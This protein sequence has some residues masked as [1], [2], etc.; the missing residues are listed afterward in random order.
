M[1]AEQPAPRILIVQTGTAGALVPA[2]GD[3]P[4]W[5]RRALGASE[6]QM[7]V[8]RTAPELGGE[9]LDPEVLF[10]TKAKGV[11]VTGSPLSAAAKEGWMEELGE[12]LL[13]AG[14]AG[15]P[16]LGVCFGHQLLGQSAGGEVARNPR[17]REIGTVQVQLTE[18]GRKDPLFSWAGA[19]TSQIDVQATHTEA[20]LPPPK[21]ATLLASNEICATQ[22]LRFSETVASVQFHPELEPQA[23]RALIRSRAEQ[24]RGEGLDPVGLEAS[25]RET[26]GRRILRAFAEQVRHA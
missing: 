3:Y 23:L 22:A 20:V 2:H 10:R 19:E 7:P 12:A 17:G 24:L 25:V 6:E 11:L 16:V 5:F 21:R 9:K 8:L 18:A 13:R 14:Q 1:S 15:T 4:D 26:D